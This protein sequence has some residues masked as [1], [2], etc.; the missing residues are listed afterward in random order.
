MP[1]STGILDK[2]A[3]Y[4]SGLFSIHGASSRGVDWN[5]SES[6]VLRFEQLL[7]I[8]DFTC[9]FSLNDFGCGYGAL[10]DFLNRSSSSFSYFGY[11]IS[12]DMIAHAQNANSGRPN[13][14]FTSDRS[15]LP[16][17]DYTVASGIFNV[18]LDVPEEDWKFYILSN[19]K[20]LSSIS[21]LGFSFNLL[22]G[23][24]DKHRMRPDLFYADPLFFFDYCKNN[25]SP[26]ISLLHDYPLF[27]FTILVRNKIYG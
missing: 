24:C 4:Y 5:S 23:Y 8:C 14:L 26:Y 16:V 25:F 3:N 15:L 18:K 10:L 2:V 22:S 21:K 6:Q 20:H 11:D 12:K 17:S 7:K 27:E 13:S 1:N 19:L 9:H